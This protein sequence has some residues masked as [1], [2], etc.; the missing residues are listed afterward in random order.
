MRALIRCD[1]AP[2]PA[3][4][5]AERWSVSKQIF[6]SGPAPS[7]N[8]RAQNL[9]G[10]VLSAVG[11]RAADLVR[12]AA[13]VYAADQDLSRGGP[14]DVYGRAWRRHIALCLPVGDPDFWQQEHVRE[15]LADVLSFLTEDRWQFH[16]SPATPE[17]RQLILDVD[18]AALLR[19]PDSVVLFSGGADSLCTA[20]EACVGHGE[21]QPKS[22]SPRTRG[23]G[24]TRT[25]PRH[26]SR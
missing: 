17:A 23:I 22:P 16:F 21:R 20:V 10:T 12:I 7:L 18:A 25:V 3:G 15:G 14:A 13:Y 1:G 26:P 8:L 9:A 2:V 5:A 4:V 11:S 24:G 6:S 19:A